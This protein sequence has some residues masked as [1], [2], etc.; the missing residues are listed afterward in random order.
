MKRNEIVAIPLMVSFNYSSGIS[1][2]FWDPFK[3]KFR[4][5]FPWKCSFG[6]FPFKIFSPMGKKQTIPTSEIVMRA[7]N[8]IQK[9]Q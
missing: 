9:H 1:D 2:R 6:I 8:F 3:K 5:K 4:Q 7:V